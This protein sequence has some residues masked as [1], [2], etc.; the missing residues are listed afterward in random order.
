MAAVNMLGA[1]NLEA[2]QTAVKTAVESVESY[3]KAEDAPSSSGD[4]GLPFLAMRQLADTTSTDSDGDYTLLKIDEEGRLKVAT[5]PASYVATTGSITTNGGIVWINCSRASNIVFSMVATSLVG[6]AAA[7][8]VSNNT[9]NGSDGTW[10]GMQAVRSNANTIETATGTLAATPAYGW[11]VSVNGWS[12]FRVRATAHTSGTAAYILQPGSYATEPI[13]AAQISGT[14]PVSGT[15]T[16]TVTPP[17]PATPYFVNSAASTNG[18][19]ILTGTSSLH[20]FYATNTGASAAY[21]KLYNKATAPTV[22]TD[23]PEMIIPVPAAVSGVPGVAT[24]PMGFLGFRFA[25]GLG[26][27]ITGG[28]ADTDTTA[29][30]SGQVKVKLSR[31]V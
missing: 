6:H 26:I 18:A 28:A 30:A 9:T 11:E 10:Y 25:L 12:A 24:L 19:L 29:V 5:K 14:Q 22:G 4:K 8:E 13:P 27:A 31:A 3:F 7:F 21:V 17:A 20:A 16:A 2:T 1:L 23:V 15:V